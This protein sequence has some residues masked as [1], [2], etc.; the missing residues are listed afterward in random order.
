MQQKDRRDMKKKMNNEIVAAICMALHQ[1]AD[2]EVH[3]EE[4]GKLCINQQPTEWTIRLATMRKLPP[5]N[6]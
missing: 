5:R 1:Y 2:A 3:D 4:T 6:F